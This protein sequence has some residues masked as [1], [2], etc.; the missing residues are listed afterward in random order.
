MIHDTQDGPVRVVVKKS[1][2]GWLSLH[3][4]AS[5]AGRYPLKT[6]VEANAHTVRIFREL[7][8]E[9]HCTRLCGSSAQSPLLSRMDNN[10]NIAQED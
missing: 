8:P 1:K 5:L 6:E 7:F 4:G 10:W 2:T 3:W 9:H